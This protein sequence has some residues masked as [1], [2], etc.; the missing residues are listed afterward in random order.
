MDGAGNFVVAWASDGADASSFGIAA[1]PFDPGGAP[2]GSEIAVNV[3]TAGTQFHPAVATAPDG[4]FVVAWDSLD[5][6]GPGVFLRRF[7]AAGAPL[8]GEVAVNTYLPNAQDTPEVARLAGGGF[9]V[10]WQ[11]THQDG[12]VRGV[13]ARRFD[14]NA[15]PLGGEIAL[16]T[17]TYDAQQ[18]PR[19]AADESGGFRV[20]WE[21]WSEDGSL[22]GVFGRSVD[23]SGAPAGPEFRV[24]TETLFNERAPAVTAD[25]DGR[26]VVAWYSSGEN[27][28]YGVRAQRY[29]DLIFKDGFESGNVGAWSTAAPDAGDLAATE[30]SALAGAFG[31]EANVDDLNPLY[32]QDDS[33]GNETHYRARFLFDPHGFDTG[34]ANLHR[35]NRVFIAFA[36]GPQR[37]VAVVVLRRQNG[38]YALLGRARLDDNTQA[39]TP[40]VPIS[41]APHTVEIDLVRASGPDA[42]DGQFEMWVDG[43]SSGRLTALDNDRGEVDFARMGALSLKSAA[44]GTLRFDAFESRRQSS[45]GPLP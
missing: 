19:V 34:E 13:F 3:L 41:D 37:R 6:S 7:T 45:I 14:A 44:S 21:G 43:V 9:A 10:T 22:A 38:L 12:S 20:V 11:S 15:A 31:L 30:S 23:G 32:V 18:F 28:S 36:E 33:P 16:N 24:N 17:Y 2:L 42:N 1:R 35:R 4:S 27:G 8:T 5:A 25:A 26:F 29:G 39:D 40:F